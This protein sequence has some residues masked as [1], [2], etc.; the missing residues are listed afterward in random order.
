MTLAEQDELDDI[1]IAQLEM[2][3]A[4]DEAIGGSTTYGITGIMQHLR[5]LG[6]A[7][8]TIVVYFSDNGWHWGEHRYRAKNKPYEESI[9][10][11]MFIRYPKLAP[12]PRVESKFALNI[13]FCPTFVELAVRSTDPQPTITSDGTSL[14]RLLDG[15]AGE[16]LANGFPHR[17]LAGEPRVGERARGAVEVHRAADHAGDPAHAIR[18]RAVRSAERSARARQRGDPP[19]PRAR[20]IDMSARIEALRPTWPDDS[21]PLFDDPNDDE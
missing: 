15:T 12:L 10:S 6:V 5:N 3:Q 18:A 20:I 14:V 4:V 17:G 8:D 1:R 21:T 13:D 19:G 2:L 7:D 9:R 16:Q 11:P